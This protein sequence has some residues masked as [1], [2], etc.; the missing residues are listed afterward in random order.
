MGSG[1]LKQRFTWNSSALGLVL[2]RFQRRGD[3][4]REG[5]GS[6]V[7]LW[8]YLE[9]ERGT[10]SMEGTSR[11]VYRG[12]TKHHPELHKRYRALENFYR[13]VGTASNMRPRTEPKVTIQTQTSSQAS[14]GE[15][16]RLAMTPLTYELLFLIEFLT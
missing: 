14:K 2:L 3:T 4:R 15:L 16:A 12:Y 10:G 1:L 11:R 9:I 6:C 7:C 5:I 13:R 8:A